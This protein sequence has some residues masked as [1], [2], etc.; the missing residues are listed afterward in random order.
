[1]G[2]LGLYDD[3]LFLFGAVMRDTLLLD[4]LEHLLFGLLQ[5]LVLFVCGEVVGTFGFEFEATE[6]LFGVICFRCFN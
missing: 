5:L 1:M 6:L 3:L 4:L 2:D